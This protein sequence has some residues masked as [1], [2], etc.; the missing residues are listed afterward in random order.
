MPADLP[1]LVDR[2]TAARLLSIK[3]STLRRWWTRGVG[4]RGVKLSTARSGR[5]MY[6]TSEIE[7][8]CR[9]PLGYARSARPDSI[10][11]YDPPQRQGGRQHGR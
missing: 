9:D 3:Q 11:A 1:A 2:P 5:V 4:P 6:P 8:F 7:A 10:P